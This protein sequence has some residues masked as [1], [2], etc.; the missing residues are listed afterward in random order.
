MRAILRFI[1]TTLVGGILF[2]VPVTILAYFLGQA[3]Q[4]ASGIVKPLLE[5][6]P[7]WTVAGVA[8]AT[9]VTIAAL[10][11]VCFAAGIVARTALARG[12]MRGVEEKILD[13]IPGYAMMR[14]MAHGWIGHQ[15]S[16]DLSTA[17]L[18]LDDGWQ[19]AIVIER[20]P[21]SRVVVFVPAAPEALTGSV[22]I[23]NADRVQPVNVPISEALRCVKRFGAGAPSFMNPTAGA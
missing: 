1:R 11:G 23:V 4:F 10:V 6:V 13:R 9:V 21:D 16:G 17:L 12:V 19:I 7:A 15:Q 22:M 3:Y 2:L 20:C 8:L 5:Y 14:S 18:R